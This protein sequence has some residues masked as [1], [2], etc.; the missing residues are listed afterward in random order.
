MNRRIW[1]EGLL[2]TAMAALIAG[3]L[4]A[5]AQPAPPWPSQP[6][7][8]IVPGG[9]G[10]G[11]DL[12]ARLFAEPLSKALRQP[13]IVEN[14]PGANGLIGN[15][16][17]AKAAPDGNTILF[18]NASA[19]SV[20]AALRATLP[21]DTLRDLAPVIQVSAG[22]VLLVAAAGVPV[23]DFSEFLEYVRA[24]PEIAY[25]TWGVGST[26][27]LAMEA[28]AHDR[29]LRMRHIPYKTMGQ[30]LTDLQ[31]G[32]VKLAF[33]DARSPVAL[34]QAGKLRPIAMTGTRRAPMLPNV[35]TLKEQGFSFDLDGWYGFFVPARTPAGIVSR[36]NGEITRVML[37]PGLQPA[38]A[39]Q[40]L[41]WVGR[42]SPE[43]FMQVIRNDIRAWKDVVV[44]A[45][46]KAD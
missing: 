38:F 16:M 42:N 13:V 30:L 1:M 40:G 46:V 20:N 12:M 22:G 37:D 9:A 34:V 36:L 7:R 26:G 29:Q 44:A 10:S 21:Y 5:R 8:M 14:R 31:G 45:Q 28:I 27:H 19:V 11:T 15:D 35:K 25:G 39:Q 4:Q 33:V 32:V 17:A 24:N 2:S 43:Q 6:V 41:A 18:S 3:P 23:R